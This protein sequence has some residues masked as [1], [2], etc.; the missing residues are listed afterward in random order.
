MRVSRQWSR[1]DT[2]AGLL[3]VG[4]LA[5]IVVPQFPDD[6]HPPIGANIE[7]LLQTIRSQIELY[8][9]RNPQAPFDARTP[10]GPSFW[11]P[12]VSGNFLHAAVENPLQNNSTVV[13]ATPAM[14]TGWVWAPWADM[15]HADDGSPYYTLQGVDEDGK[16]YDSD[17]DGLP[18]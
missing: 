11:D 4:I 7:G 13:G 12:L 14:G 6:H 10:V 8:N 5:A 15:V 3:I 9:V 17:Q 18:D 16:L 2:I 1:Y